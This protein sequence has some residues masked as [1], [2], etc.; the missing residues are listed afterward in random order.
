[1]T[2]PALKLDDLNWSSMV[3][4]IRTRI[5]AN[6]RGQWT[7]HG[8]VDTGI[9]LLELFTYLF[10]QRIYWLDQVHAPLA[11]A[12]GVDEDRGGRVRRLVGWQVVAGIAGVLGVAAPVRRAAAAERR[13]EEY[14]DD[15][16]PTREPD[17]GASR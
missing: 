10:E 1:M 6:S 11:R 16:G 7:M 9:T 12:A 15:K 5:V 8:P 4:A 3:D 2:L 14:G 17:H 13:R